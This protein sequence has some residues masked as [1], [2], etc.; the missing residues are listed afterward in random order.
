MRQ[1]LLSVVMMVAILGFSFGAGGLL[2]DLISNGKPGGSDYKG[3]ARRKIIA[4]EVAGIVGGII[5]FPVAISSADQPVYSPKTLGSADRALVEG[6]NQ[7]RAP[8]EKSVLSLAKS[9]GSGFSGRNWYFDIKRVGEFTLEVRL[10]GNTAKSCVSYNPA[11]TF[12][13][14]TSGSCKS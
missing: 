3:W 5:L 8:S 9:V 2:Y 14:W 6:L 11:S 12:W 1:F 7:R 13:S 10:S 4:L